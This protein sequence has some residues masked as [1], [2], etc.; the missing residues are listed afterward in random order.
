MKLTQV[1]IS[2]GL[3]Q[4]LV[5]HYTP[6]LAKIRARAENPILAEV[7]RLPILWQIAHIKTLLEMAVLKESDDRG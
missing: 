7:D 2:S 4:K 1:E 5:D 3:W 6:I